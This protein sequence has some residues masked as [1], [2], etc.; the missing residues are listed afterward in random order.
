VRK[1]VKKLFNNSNGSLTIESTLAIPFFIFAFFSLIS[2]ANQARTE[3]IMQNTISQVA[4]EIS[5]Y[6][7]I[8]DKAKSTSI[9]LNTTSD[10]SNQLSQNFLSLSKIPQFE[11]SSTTNTTNDLSKPSTH[12]FN[13]FVNLLGSTFNQELLIAMIVKPYCLS[14]FEENLKVRNS[15]LSIEDYLESLQI[16]GGMNGLDFRDSKIL[17]DGRSIQINVSYSVKSMFPLFL[18]KNKTI[19]Q[20]ASTAAWVKS[21]LFESENKLSKWKLGSLSRGRAWLEEIRSENCEIAVAPG[22]GVDLYEEGNCTFVYSINVFTSSYCLGNLQDGTFQLNKQKMKEQLKTYS[23]K[24]H[25]QTSKLND[26][27]EM[28]NGKIIAVANS[29]R[30]TIKMII[31]EES[32]QYSDV[33]NQ[34]SD[35]IKNEN[36]ISVVWDFREKAL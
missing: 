29:K 26:R 17:L 7:Y 27:I 4:K 19:K 24:S 5:I 13:N 36:G 25:A 33:L 35:E 1:V 3:S 22:V 15:T 2:F 11:E 34:L 31:P 20:S 9:Q 23:I 18:K 21:A 10:T 30:I 32:V 8:A 16:E 28:Q 12:I 14:K 6:F